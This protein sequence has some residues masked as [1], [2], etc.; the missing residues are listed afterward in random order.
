MLACEDLGCSVKTELLVFLRLQGISQKRRM[1]IVPDL[2]LVERKCG[3]DA[4]TYTRLPAKFQA[5][6]RQFC[7]LF[8]PFRSQFLEAHARE[9]SRNIYNWSCESGDLDNE[10][11]YDQESIRQGN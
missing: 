8:L 2:Y 10:L 3:R 9:P 1:F 11:T 4:G 7:V 5:N 6:M